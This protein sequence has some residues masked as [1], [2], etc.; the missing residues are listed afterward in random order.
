MKKIFLFLLLALLPALCTAR[1]GAKNFVV[2]SYEVPTYAVTI[3]TPNITG[4]FWIQTDQDIYLNLESS[5]TPNV[6]TGIFLLQNQDR[7]MW[8]IKFKNYDSYGTELSMIAGSATAN[9][10]IMW[11]DQ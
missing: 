8:P 4:S 9:V 3:I 2:R 1:D 5:A 6:N 7:D 10:N 11:Y